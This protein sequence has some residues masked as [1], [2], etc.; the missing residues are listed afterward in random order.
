MSRQGLDAGDALLPLQPEQEPA[1]IAFDAPWKARAF[2]ITLALAESGRVR[3]DAFQQLFGALIA[4]ADRSGGG[5]AAPDYYTLWLTALEQLVDEALDL[6][7]GALEAME[8]RVTAKAIET[9][10]H[11]HVASRDEAGNLI[12]K[13]IF[14]EAAHNGAVA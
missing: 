1:R 9:R 13:P 12:I 5:H 11:Q 7:S 2:A 10:H 14:V 4:A 6:C 3:R 8:R